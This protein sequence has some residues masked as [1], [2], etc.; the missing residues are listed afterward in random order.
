[1]RTTL[2][3]ATALA[4]PRTDRSARGGEFPLLPRHRVKWSAALLHYVLRAKQRVLFLCLAFSLPHDDVA[5]FCVCYFK[6]RKWKMLCARLPGRRV[7]EYKRSS[8]Q[9]PTFKCFSQQQVM[10]EKYKMYF[11]LFH[12]SHSLSSAAL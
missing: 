2:G 7:N 12:F 10:M 3:G 9:R 6:F 5:L 4:Q 11:V 1:M 8:A